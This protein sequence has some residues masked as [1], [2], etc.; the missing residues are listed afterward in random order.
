VIVHGET[1]TGRTTLLT[2]VAAAGAD[3][4]TILTTR[5]YEPERPLRRAGLQR[6]LGPLVDRSTE[7]EPAAVL[8]I[9]T[10]AARERPVLCC[11]D[12][13]HWLD[14]DT[15]TVL[16]QLSR[17]VGTRPIAIL[18]STCDGVLAPAELM[19]DVA[20]MELTALDDEASLAVLADLVAEGP[21]GTDGPGGLAGDV[22][23]AVIELA[24]GNP[25][26]LVDLARWLTPEQRRGDA[27][28]PPSLPPGSTLWR[29]YQG[30]LR[31]LP[32]EAWWLVMLA[33]AD[34][35]LSVAELDRAARAS[36]TAIAALAP[37][38]RANLVRR[39]DQAIVFPQPLVRSIVYN[40]AT[41][42]RRHEAHHLLAD[43]L[44]PGTLRQ[45]LH[46]SSTV[47]HSDDGLAEHLRRAAQGAGRLAASRARRR[48]AELTTDSALAAD[49]LVAAA[50]L[51]W[52]GGRPHQARITLRRLRPAWAELVAGPVELLRTEIDLRC[53]PS[54]RLRRPA[55]FPAGPPAATLRAG[56]ALLMSGACAQYADL[57][58]H[59]RLLANNVRGLE[60]LFRADFRRAGSTT[61]S[62]R[63]PGPG[64]GR[65][66]GPEPGRTRRR[67][68]G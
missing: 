36:G 48:A 41:F 4:F 14:P 55:T 43:T 20:T 54:P 35:E 11:V 68:D 47:D 65:P 31:R 44:D 21:D 26:A 66:G 25:R 32:V 56:A 63:E 30:R 9:L 1:G 34:P 37:A 13:A 64:P 53:G 5:G 46:R 38:E 24:G 19:P 27:A 22:A 39:A 59:D 33:A 49:D 67:T 50:R 12:D 6:L 60:L 8:R 18:L 52:E 61:A 29:E 17:K 23:S 45:L 40:G 16:R 3:E 2:A 58:R 51:A 42:A 15:L 7:S 62:R 57:A 10:A 28:L